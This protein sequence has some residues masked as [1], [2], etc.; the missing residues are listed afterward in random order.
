MPHYIGVFR[1]EN[2]QEY[3]HVGSKATPSPKKKK[4]LPGHKND[5]DKSV[6]LPR[7]NFSGK[8]SKHVSNFNSARGNRQKPDDTETSEESEVFNHCWHQN[9]VAVFYYLIHLLSYFM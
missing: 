1:T 2:T 9:T 7:L 5:K 4:K 6:K 3:V 8:N